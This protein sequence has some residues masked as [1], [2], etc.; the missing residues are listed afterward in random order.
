MIKVAYLNKLEDICKWEYSGECEILVFEYNNGELDFENSISI[1][2]D[3]SVKNNNIYSVASEFEKIVRMCKSGKNLIEISDRLCIKS[4][5][6]IG[7]DI[8]VE[9]AGAL[10]KLY[11]NIKYAV[12]RNLNK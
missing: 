10:G 9:K 11:K 4:M 7:E 1:W 2:L 8:L 6:N 3:R 12:R 5:I